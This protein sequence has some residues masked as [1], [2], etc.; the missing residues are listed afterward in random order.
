MLKE[1]NASRSQM[2]LSLKIIL[3]F[4]ILPFKNIDSMRDFS[5]VKQSCDSGVQTSDNSC[6]FSK[7]TERERKE[8]REREK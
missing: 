1:G 3:G 4:L 6:L 2:L 5:V 7:E 8:E